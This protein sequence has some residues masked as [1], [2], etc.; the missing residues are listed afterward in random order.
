MKQ[1][2]AIYRNVQRFDD[3]MDMERQIAA[4]EPNDPEAFYIMG[5]FDWTLA[6]KRMQ[7]TRLPRMDWLTMA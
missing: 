6:Y 1:E 7:S 2:A 4:I 5:F 3:A